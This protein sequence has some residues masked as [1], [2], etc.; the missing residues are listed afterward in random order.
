MCNTLLKFTTANLLKIRISN[1]KRSDERF[2]K[3]ETG[4]IK[5]L[6]EDGCYNEQIA[7]REQFGK[8]GYN[9]KR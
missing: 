4:K 8:L 3:I 1:K 6:K 9:Y 5:A 2:N 7:F